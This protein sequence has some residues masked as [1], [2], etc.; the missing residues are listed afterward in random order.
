MIPQTISTHKNSISTVRGSI[1]REITL[2][3]EED[4]EITYSYQIL[5]ENYAKGL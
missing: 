3:N 4:S 1:W 2:I 5:Y